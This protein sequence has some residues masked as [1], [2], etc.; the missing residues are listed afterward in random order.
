M[1]GECKDGVGGEREGEHERE[2]E[3]EREGIGAGE[4]EGE[5][6]GKVANACE[7]EDGAESSGPPPASHTCV[8]MHKHA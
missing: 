6:G 1:E 3:R 7:C 2:G 8:P 4:S 5:D